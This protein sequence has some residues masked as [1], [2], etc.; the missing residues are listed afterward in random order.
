[1]SPKT[2]SGEVPVATVQR[3]EYLFVRGNRR[4]PDALSTGTGATCLL[5][6]HRGC[7]SNQFYW[8]R[9]SRYDNTYLFLMVEH[10]AFNA[11][12]KRCFWVL[13]VFGQLCIC[14]FCY[15]HEYFWIVNRSYLQQGIVV[16]TSQ[17]RTLDW[18]MTHLGE[19][20]RISPH[21]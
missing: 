18:W 13:L 12:F 2:F 7:V 5:S 21:D 10:F 4:F 20:P 16:Q 11:F 3:K 17:T 19:S 8:G 9:R 1:M 14:Q 6:G 15:I